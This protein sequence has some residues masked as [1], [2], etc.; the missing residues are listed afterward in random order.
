MRAVGQDLVPALPLSADCMMH[1]MMVSKA[2]LVGSYQ[3]KLE[4]IAGYDG[5]ELAVVV[6]PVWEDP[7]GR[8]TLE[9]SH[10]EGYRLFV[11][12]LRLNGHYH[13]HYY[14]RLDQRLDQFRPDILHIDEEPYNVATWLAMRAAK[15]RGIRSLFFSWQN[16]HRDYP[17]P[18]RWM[19]RWVLEHADYAIAGNEAAAGV[20]RAKGYAGPLR[21]IPQFGVDPALFHPPDRRDRGATFAIGYAG[22][23]VPEKGVDLLLKALADLPGLWQLHVTGE[24]PERAALQRLAAELGIDERVHFDGA[25]ANREMPAYLRRLDALV[26]A[27]RT[28]ANWT[29]QFGR[30]LVEAMASGVAVVGAASGEIPNVI[31]PAGLVFPE[32]D[33]AALAG[34][35]R[36]LLAEEGLRETLGNAGRKR[37]LQ[38]YTQA[39]VAAATVAV[40]RE[41]VEA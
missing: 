32:G 30:V 27:S 2:C 35:L 8:V 18:F 24:G 12:P 5:V 40:Y 36:R 13:L 37:V 3:T 22:R 1:V 26:L 33:A 23:L 31:G 16:L 39:Q 6:P 17:P 7:A 14:P 9:R 29:E 38:Q 11:D 15:A 25:I 20:W 41:I 28:L 21:V 4:A 34:C 10:T 19:E